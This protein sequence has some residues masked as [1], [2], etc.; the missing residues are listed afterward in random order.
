MTPGNNA[1]AARDGIADTSAPRVWSD[2]RETFA[3]LESATAG[4]A[5]AVICCD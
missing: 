3:N 1:S 2:P 4:L 5:R